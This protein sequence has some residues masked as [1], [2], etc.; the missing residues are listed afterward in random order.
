ML[1]LAKQIEDQDP[2]KLGAF[3]LVGQGKAFL[4]NTTPRQRKDLIRNALL[5]KVQFALFRSFY[6]A[7]S[8][9]AAEENLASFSRFRLTM[10]P[11]IK[12]CNQELPLKLGLEFSDVRLCVL[13]KFKKRKFKELW[14]I[15][16]TI[17]VLSF[18]QSKIRTS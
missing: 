8:P 1:K 4:D 7:I 5:S 12:Y 11:S 10:N 17:I 15:L 14:L 6:K 18:Y 13:C 3:D 2:N 9:F 16:L